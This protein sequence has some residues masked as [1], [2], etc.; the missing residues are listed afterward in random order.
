MLI[1]IGLTAGFVAGIWGA[2]PLGLMLAGIAIIVAWLVS[3]GTSVRGFLGQRSTQAGTNALVSTLAVVI[4]L[5][6]LNFLAVRYVSRIDLTENQIFTLAPQTQE[7]MQQLEQ[8]VKAWLFDPAENPQDR[9]LLDNYRRQNNKFSYEYVNPDAQPGVAQEFG[10][11]APGEV[12]LEQGDRRRL[13]QVVSD[14][15]RLSERR[16]T[17]GIA[18]LATDRQAKVYFLQGHGERSLQ[19]GQ[20]GVTEASTRLQEESYVTEPLNLAEQ[21]EVPEDA[22]AVVVAGPERALLEEEVTALEEYLSQ[23]RSGLVLLIDP[24]VNPELTDLLNQW[25]VSLVDRVVV[26]PT[27]QAS[28][29]EALVTLVTQYGDH[30]ITQNL[31]NGISF[32]PIARPIDL[33]PVDGVEAVPLLAT[34]DRVQAQRIGENGQLAFD[35]ATDPAG[36]L[37]IGAALSR[38]V[39]ADTP[40]ASPSPEASPSPGASP[41][42]SP[43][44]EASPAAPSEARLVVIGNS[45]F[46][47]DGLFNQ[48]LNADVFLNSVSWVSQQ[49]NNQVLAVRPKEMTNRRILLQPQRQI[50]LALLSLVFLPLLGFGMGVAIWWSRR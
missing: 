37:L 14:Q 31:A 38:P 34:S 18:Q 41:S 49:D 20:A 23:R 27:R 25:G 29:P 3:E 1:I 19:A 40:T 9:Q 13:L 39:E 16:L 21:G 36:Q 26:D 35:P 28:G 44:P 12:Y 11:K 7:V 8:P 43:S 24:N 4:I 6:L 33:K 45:S 22:T 2:V 47:T 17:N 50:L 48:Q 42:P 46:I 10:V 15:E 32:Y 30:P 5:G